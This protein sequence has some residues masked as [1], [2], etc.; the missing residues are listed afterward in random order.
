[1]RRIGATSSSGIPI[2]GRIS[3]K[4][5]AG[6]STATTRPGQPISSAP[7]PDHFCLTGPS[8]LPDPRTHAYRRDIADV[9]LASALFAPR[10]RNE[11]DHRITAPLAPVL[12]EAD[13]KS[14][15][16]A[17]WSMGAR[18][19]GS[20]KGKFI[21][22]EDG[23]YVHGRHAAPLH[24]TS[25]DYVA[26]AEQLIG[27]PYLWGGRGA[28]GIDCSGLVQIALNLAGVGC[29]RDSDQQQAALGLEL[30]ADAPLRRGDLI[31]FP[32]HVGMMADD[33]MLL[34]ANAHW[35]AVAREPL[36]D[37]VARLAPDHTQ[38]VSARRRL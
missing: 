10:A 4:A 32:G 26:T 8:R 31:F 16:I 14:P 20:A 28:G 37:V 33:Q 6:S 5:S 21:A 27:Q 11:P 25:E 34:H 17:T 19:A 22:I 36:A 24:I 3:L 1:M 13:I 30:P 7:W 15:V 2:R 29:P 38:P 18:F 35:M 9:E 12:A 23:G